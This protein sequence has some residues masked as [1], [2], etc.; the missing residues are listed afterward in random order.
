ME[1]LM[2]NQ[3][4]CLLLNY[5]YN[6][7]CQHL[8]PTD[9]DKLNQYAQINN[10]VLVATVEAQHGTH[11]N[12]N[13]KNKKCIKMMSDNPEPP[14]RNIKWLIISPVGNSM[15]VCVCEG[16]R[17]NG[18]VSTMRKGR[19]PSK[20]RIWLREHSIFNSKF[21]NHVLDKKGILRVNV[22]NI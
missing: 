1:W 8:P 14:R 13:T 3:A 22:A 15:C 6:P 9:W 10:M 20:I 11:W 21:N 16:M 4:W 19:K 7:A 2:W 12:R 17:G 5:Q 18:C